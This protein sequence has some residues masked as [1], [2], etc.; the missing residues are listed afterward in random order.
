MLSTAELMRDLGATSVGISSR[1]ADAV[2]YRDF[3]IEVLPEFIPFAER[4]P[5]TSSAV[6]AAKAIAWLLL[7][8]DLFFSREFGI[9]LIAHS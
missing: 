4:A 1:Y 8:W 7:A 5:G 2:A 3:G 9:F 6:R